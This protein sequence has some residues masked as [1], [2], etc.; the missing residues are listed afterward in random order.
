MIKSREDVD[1]WAP[2][3]KKSD[4]VEGKKA[5]NIKKKS[6]FSKKLE[7]SHDT[8]DSKKSQFVDI[9]EISVQL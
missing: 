1:N 4:K 9:D 5:L 3:E 2:V 6:E 8:I 7:S